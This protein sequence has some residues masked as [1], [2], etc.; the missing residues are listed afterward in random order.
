MYFDRSRRR[1]LRPSDNEFLPVLA[2]TGTLGFGA[3][4]VAVGAI[5]P[6]KNY[7]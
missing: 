3:L 4:E 1:R 6:G 7:Y 5:R 2:T